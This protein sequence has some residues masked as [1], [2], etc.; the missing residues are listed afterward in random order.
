MSLKNKIVTITTACLLALT[1]TGCITNVTSIKDGKLD[2]NT[3]TIEHV[4]GWPS[5]DLAKLYDKDKILK[6]AISDG[7]SGIE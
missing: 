6:L 3:F 2:D 7:G 4:S 1:T 5:F